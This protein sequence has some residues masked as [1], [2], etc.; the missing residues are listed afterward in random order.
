MQITAFTREFMAPLPVDSRL[1]FS[2]IKTLAFT[3]KKLDPPR[4]GNLNVKYALQAFLESRGISRS[5]A[6]LTPP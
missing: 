6:N 4:L 3:S 5:H 2:G 1:N